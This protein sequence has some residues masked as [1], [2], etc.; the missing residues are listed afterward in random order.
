MFKTVSIFF[1]Q[2]TQILDVHVPTDEIYDSAVEI[3]IKDI[4][5]LI[6]KEKSPLN[7]MI[8]TR[9]LSL[10]FLRG[11]TKEDTETDEH[12]I[13]NVPPPPAEEEEKHNPAETVIEVEEPEDPN[14]PL[15]EGGAHPVRTKINEQ[16]INKFN[17]PSVAR[18]QELEADLPTGQ[19]GQVTLE[20]EPK[21]EE[22]KVIDHDYEVDLRE[23]SGIYTYALFRG[24]KARGKLDG[25]SVRFEV[26]KIKC[27]LHLVKASEYKPN[28]AEIA[29]IQDLY[30]PRNYEV[31]KN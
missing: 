23:G 16:V 29:F 26:G 24:K 10:S 28:P 9:S 1:L 19:V 30:T 31:K 2:K 18:A 17:K 6:Q 12:P 25:A 21:P 27:K 13:V 15:L 20:E 22:K 4:R 14:R 8:A 11:H 3:R 7:P 5:D